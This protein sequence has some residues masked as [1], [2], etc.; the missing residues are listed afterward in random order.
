[1]IYYTDKNNNTGYVP[2]KNYLKQM[3]THILNHYN[4]YLEANCLVLIPN[5]ANDLVEYFSDS[6]NKSLDIVYL[7]KNHWIN[8]LNKISIDNSIIILDDILCHG[9]TLKNIVKA[10][11]NISS[12]KLII[13]PFH[14]VSKEVCLY[15]IVEKNFTLKA[16]N[17]L[18]YLYFI[19]EK[20]MLK[21][22]ILIFESSNF[23]LM[24]SDIKQF[25]QDYKF[26]QDGK[27]IRIEEVLNQL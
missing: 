25:G 7:N 13:I 20:F 26:Y 8:E 9:E 27:N 12:I 10:V 2:D 21:I 18:Y 1:M 24:K 4:K 16:Q 3:F 19:K 5:A 15:D 22:P 14:I 11:A 23:I 17:K 6:L